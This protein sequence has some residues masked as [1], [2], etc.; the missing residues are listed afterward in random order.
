MRKAR[1]IS[2]R[3]I[4][5]LIG[6]LR[7]GVRYRIRPKPKDHLA[8][9]V[10]ALSMEHPRYGQVRIWALLRRSNVVV[11]YKAVSQLWQ[12]L[13][14]EL[15]RRT[16]RKMVRAGESVPRVAEHPNHVWTYDFVFARILGGTQLRF[17]TLEDEHTRESLA[18]EV[19]RTFKVV[20]VRE[21]LARFFG[22]RGIPRLIPATT[23][24]CS[25][26]W[27]SGCGGST[28]ASAPT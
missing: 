8:E 1:R 4:A 22:E 20:H 10:M 25:L 13:G 5:A 19:G 7:S 6:I 24:R 21:V 3:R 28:R 15:T 17:L 18:S 16:R 2:E 9:Q 27:R 23:A 26:P 14:L 12:K 11:N